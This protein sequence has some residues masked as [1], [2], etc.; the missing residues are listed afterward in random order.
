MSYDYDIA[1]VGGGAGGLSLA[2]GAS[3]LGLRVVLFEAHKMGGGLLKL[4]LC[5]V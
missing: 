4:W 3:Q 1:I 5:A 2:A